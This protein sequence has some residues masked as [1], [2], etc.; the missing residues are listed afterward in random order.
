MTEL[1]EDQL[2]KVQA[3]VDELVKELLEVLEGHNHG[4]ILSAFGQVV[5]MTATHWVDLMQR[6]NAIGEMAAITYYENNA[7]TEH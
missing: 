2:D 4:V 7:P 3:E 1:T 6:T 5:G